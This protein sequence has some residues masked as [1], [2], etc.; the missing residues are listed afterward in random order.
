[1]KNGIL[2]PDGV[3]ELGA[4][5]WKRTWTPLKK[6]MA[7]LKRLFEI[8]AKMGYDGTVSIEDFSNEESTRDKL[9]QN[10]EYLR[11]LADAA[12]KAE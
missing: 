5:K 4:C 3:D 6:G 2:A 10:L 12:A 11:Q 8:M 9:A 7:N 1:M